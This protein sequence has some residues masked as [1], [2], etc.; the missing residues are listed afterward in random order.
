MFETINLSN[1]YLY[2]HQLR[3][4]AKKQYQLV[5]KHMAKIKRV[6]LKKIVYSDYPDAFDYVDKLFSTVGVKEVDIYKVSASSLERMG[7]GGAEG[8]YDKLSKIIVVS[9]V[10]SAHRMGNRKYCVRAKVSR[11]EVIVHELCHYCYTDIGHRSVS[12][13]MAEEFAYGWS[14]GYLRSKGYSDEYIIEYNFL[15][16]L[17]GV[18]YDEATEN[19]LASIEVGV[20]EYNNYSVYK[21]RQ[22]S[23]RYG[24]KVFLRAK[25]L[26]IDIGWRLIEFY[27]TKL[28]K[29]SEY[30]YVTDSDVDR[31]DLLDL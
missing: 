7:Y 1:A 28:N 30:V 6:A 25:E 8:F 9:T 16:H 27:S 26:G 31:F 13:E 23:R 4:D 11:D 3:Q 14:L 5:Q 29:G 15:P 21:K 22:F 2:D 10:K 24:K 18:A 20:A 19:I 17:L 12:R